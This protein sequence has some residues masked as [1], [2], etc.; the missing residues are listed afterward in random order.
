MSYHIYTTKGIVLSERPY[1]EAD[2]I[3]S[4]FTR[5]FGLIRA[6]ATGVRKLESKLRG[7]LEPLT[8][9]NIS[10]VRGKDYWRITSTEFIQKLDHS[11]ELAKP[12]A[13]LEKLVQGEAAHPE[14]FDVI[15]GFVFKDDKG[16]NFE[17]Q[18]VSEILHQ[19][20]YLKSED[21]TLPKSELIKA[22]N[23][24]LEASHL[25]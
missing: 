7:A 3:Y 23:A 16:E 22:I 5:D 12:L 1:Q 15:Q 2:R 6:T 13:L 19:L 21:L 8:L 10:L 18:F 9:S 24:G 4:I 25:T 17:I 14:L 11:L 20:G